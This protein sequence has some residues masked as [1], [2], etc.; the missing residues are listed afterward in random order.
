LVAEVVDGLPQ[1]V[2]SVG[3]V[4]QRTRDTILEVLRH[5]HVIRIDDLAIAA[6]CSATDAGTI[7]ADD[8]ATFGTLGSP[9]V[10]AFDRSP[11]AE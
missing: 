8:P 4:H 3:P 1:R 9:P 5:F 10:L 7:V 6:G 11:P 2:S